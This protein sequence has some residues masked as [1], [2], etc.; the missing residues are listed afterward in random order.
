M[1]RLP[2]KSRG[3]HVI[4]RMILQELPELQSFEIGLANLFSAH[5]RDPYP[6][7]LSGMMMHKYGIPREACA[8]AVQHTSASLTINENASP[9]VPLDLNVRRP[10]VAELSSGP[11]SV[12]SINGWLSHAGPVGHKPLHTCMSLAQ[13]ALDK[14]VPE[15]RHYRHDDEGSDDMPAHV[16]ARHPWF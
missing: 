3:C 6:T 13:D 14:I 4:T 12:M 1:V 8:A 5:L 15:G 16:K 11:G 10:H 7:L 9:D 2:A